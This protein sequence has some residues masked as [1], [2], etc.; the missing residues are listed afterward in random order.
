MSGPIPKREEERRRRNTTTE[1]GVPNEAEKVEV[2]EGPVPS[3]P[4][5]DHWH[6]DVKEFYQSVI[7]SA[8]SRFY[9]PSDWAALKF[10]CETMSRL[11]KPQ[12]MAV[13]QA[14][15]SVEI[16]WIKQ[17]I[18]GTDLSAL[19]KAW[20][21]LLITDGDRRRLRLEIQRGADKPREA[22]T[23]DQVT[24]DRASLFSIPGGKA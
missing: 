16:E 9:E 15:G 4:M 11:L 19:T 23:A 13:A 1:A 3:L 14:D 18:K 6:D 12:P 7:D 2:D 10:V 24:Q 17:P 22:T 5:H 21:V 8:F 20:G